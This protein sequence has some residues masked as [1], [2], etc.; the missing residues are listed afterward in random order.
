MSKHL[1]RMTIYDAEHYTDEERAAIIASYPAHERDARSK[2]IPIL[3]SGRCYPVSEED[4]SCDIFDIPKHWHRIGALDFGWEHP[5][6]A[7]D[8][9]HDTDD[10]IVYVVK[11]YKK[12]EATPTVHCQTLKKWKMPIW[13]WP[14]D[15]EMR[16]RGSGKQFSKQYAE[17]GLEMLPMHAQFDDGSISVAA[18]VSEILTRMQDGRFKVFRHLED[19]F[20]EFRNYHRKDGVIVAELDDLMSATRYGV[21]MLRFAEAVKTKTVRATHKKRSTI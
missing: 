3:G 5:T 10:D 4:I 19:W 9:A 6:A 20:S 12:T 14:H 16:E 2:G 13:T 15:G 17:E 11:T 8:L 1:T 21:V 18:G 7:V